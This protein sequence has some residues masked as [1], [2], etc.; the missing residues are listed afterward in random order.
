MA[1]S[2][3]DA[4]GPYLDTGTTTVPTVRANVEIEFHTNVE[5][6]TGSKN[7]PTVTATTHVPHRDKNSPR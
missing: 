2:G 5:V 6:D 1:Q 3:T 4:Y 7:A